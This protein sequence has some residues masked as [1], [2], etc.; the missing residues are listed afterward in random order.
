MLA[1][2]TGLVTEKLS[3]SEKQ[4]YDKIKIFKTF[5]QASHNWHLLHFILQKTKDG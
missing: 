5:H 2:K 3:K 4:I 1:Q